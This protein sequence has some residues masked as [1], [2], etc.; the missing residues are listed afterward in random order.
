MVVGGGPGGMEAARV[1]ALRG[2]SVTLYERQRELGGQLVPASA[3][4]YKHELLKLRDYLAR[5]LEKAG[6]TV[7]LGADVTPELVQREKPD[8]FVSAIGPVSMAPDI[9]GLDRLPVAT[10]LQILSGEAEMG[11]RVVVIG[12][13]L[14][15]C[16][17]AD[18]LSDRG[19]EVTVVRRGPEMAT[20]IFPSLR[21][22]LLARLDGKGVLL[23][24]GIRE[25][26]EVTQEGLVVLDGDGQRRTLPADSIA[27]ATGSTPNDRLAKSVEGMVGQVYRAGDCVEPG[28]IVDAIQDGARIG[29]EI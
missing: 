13:E 25:Y 24:P 26:A 10:D 15:G 8:A 3:P 17:T 7:R 4:P 22:A 27:L 2:H 9:P 20:G 21:E 19:R 29:C 16:E 12:G 5:Q 28:R 1:A 11:R 6:V 18:Y 14:S 23:M